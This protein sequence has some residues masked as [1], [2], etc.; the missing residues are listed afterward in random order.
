[1]LDPDAPLPAGAPAAQA[2]VLD[3]ALDLLDMRHAKALIYET[4]PALARAR[5]ALLTRRAAVPV[6][7]A[8]LDIAPP[9]LSRPEVGHGS[10]RLGLGGGLLERRGEA[11]TGLASLDFRLCLNDLLDPPDGYPAEA[12]IE[13]LPTRLRYDG[14]REQVE[15]DQS[16]FVRI[17]S[18]APWT[19]FDQRTSWHFKL[20]AEAVRDS[21]CPSCV[22]FVAAG[23]AGLAGAG[24][25]GALHA[26]LFADG[27]VEAAPD[28]RGIGGSGLRLGV[29]PTGLLRLR[30]GSR[31]GLLLGGNWTWLPG[32]PTGETWTLSAA[33]RLHLGRAASLALEYRR[34]PSEQALGLVLYLFASP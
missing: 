19:R 24:F 15:L 22:A 2:A 21:G 7:S 17:V 18:L 27:S 16:L 11:R 34:R 33:G 32:T 30:A 1:M 5:Q 6:Q 14:A 26:A 13:F 3:A 20:G 25:G 12:Q 4:D 23:G 28:L 29:G 9:E 10:L 31:A 8:A